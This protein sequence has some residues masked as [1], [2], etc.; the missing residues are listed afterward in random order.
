ML[1]FQIHETLHSV[2]GDTESAFEHPANVEKCWTHHSSES[3]RGV[4]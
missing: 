4:G 2:Q 3:K 1:S